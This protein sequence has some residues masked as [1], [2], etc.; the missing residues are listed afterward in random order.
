MSRFRAALAVYGVL[1]AAVTPWLRRWLL[2]R[3]ARGK[4]DAVRLEERFGHAA[5]PRPSGKLLWLHAASVG[6]AQSALALLRHLAVAY[7]ALSFLVTTGTVTSAALVAKAALPRSMHQYV[8][9]DTPASVRRFLQHWQPDVALWV[10]SEFWPQLLHQ[11]HATGVPIALIN[12]RMSARS[13]QG[14]A[15]FPFMIRGLFSCF[16]SIYAGSPEDAARLRALGA[17]AVIEAGN[18]KYDAAPLPVDETLVA[19]LR[20]AIAARPCFVAASTH[21]GE[22]EIIADAVQQLRATFPDLLCI[23][24]PRHAVRGDAVAALCHHRNIQISQRSK[25]EPITADTAL[26]LADTMGE[27][28][29]FYALA[30]IVFLGGSLVPVGGHNPIEPAQFGCALVTGNHLHNFTAMMEDLRQHEAL[31]QVAS[32][33]TL[34]TTLDALLRDVPRRQHMAG[35]A[36]ERIRVAQGVSREIILQIGTWLHAEVA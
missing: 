25:H 11:T 2:R 20:E 28:G 1:G 36:Q 34:A 16:S 21:E 3:A 17:N 24:I 31:I 35:I 9:V 15:R 5:Q 4:E 27:L 33:A 7:P 12:A 22:E 18:L 29:S 32:A 23:L 26:Y 6:E 14:W 19:M 10:E 8:P 30:E 13:A